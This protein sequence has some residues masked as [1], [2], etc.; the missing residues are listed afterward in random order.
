MK[1]TFACALMAVVSQAAKVEGVTKLTDVF[2]DLEYAYATYVA[3][4]S[5]T[6]KYVAEFEKRKNIFADTQAFIKDHNT[7]SEASY[8]VGHNFF[9][10]MTESE[11]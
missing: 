10:D 7:N 1:S 2:A 5:K 11:F 4:F 6:Y 3:K 8:K 9:S